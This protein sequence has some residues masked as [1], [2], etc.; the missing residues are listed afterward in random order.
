MPLCLAL[1]HYPVINK[2]GK[3][4]TT[5]I[6]NFDI[7]DIARSCRTFGVDRYFLVTPSEPQQWLARR[8]VS[9]WQ[10]GWGSTYNPNRRDALD[11]IEVVP[12]IGQMIDRCQALW[13][14]DPVFIGTTAKPSRKT[15][16]MDELAERVQEADAVHCLVFGTGWGLHP[17]FL[18]EMD[19]LLEPISGT[20]DYRHLSVRA[21][22]AIYLDRLRGRPG[23]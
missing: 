3:T 21:A 14:R 12:D 5:S 16:K 11:L 17:E 23:P 9:H 15:L 22:V 2:H 7:H 10:D 13:G 1:I 6:T 18:E 4:V 20:G 19:F 8:I